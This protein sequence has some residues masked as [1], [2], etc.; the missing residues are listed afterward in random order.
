MKKIIENSKHI[1]GDL[2]EPRPK[3]TGP[4]KEAVGWT[5]V[6]E[7]P[8]CYPN[9]HSKSFLYRLCGIVKYI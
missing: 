8:E 9:P 4:V 6:Q 7:E 1:H 5:N 2:G 3:H